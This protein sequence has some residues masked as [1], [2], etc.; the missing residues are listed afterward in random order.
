MLSP[1]KLYL[2]IVEEW[3]ES[4]VKHDGATGQRAYCFRPHIARNST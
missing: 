4:S 3:Y 2:G 1:V